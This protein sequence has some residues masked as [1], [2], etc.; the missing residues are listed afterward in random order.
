MESETNDDN[1]TEDSSLEPLEDTGTGT[2]TATESDSDS[3]DANETETEATWSDED[4]LLQIA[5]NTATTKT[6]AAGLLAIMV[7]GLVLLGILVVRRT[8]T[9]TNVASATSTTSASGA[10]AS[11]AAAS[12]AGEPCV[13]TSDPLPAGAPAVDVDEGP[14]PTDLVIKDIKE[15]TGTAVVATDTVTVNY[16][17]QACS[18]GKILDS[19]YKNGSARHHRAQPSDSRRLGRHHR[20]EGRRRAPD[21]HPER[22]GLRL[23]R[24]SAHHRARRIDLVRR[25][26]D[27]HHG[28]LI[29]DPALSAPRAND[30]ARRRGSFECAAERFFRLVAHAVRNADDTEFGGGEEFLGEVHAPLGEVADR[31]A[32]EDIPEALVEHRARDR[33]FGGE[34]G[35]GPSALG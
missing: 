7:V 34:F 18:S 14:P 10:D 13:A 17:V 20:H 16:I 24:Q 26:S 5:R 28:G 35:N 15:G 31:R 8:D 27:G 30:S 29:T 33:N 4:L 11:A 23:D 22:P 25:R 19:S 1:V 6:L 32:S 2:V 12:V 21:R 3:A 9:T